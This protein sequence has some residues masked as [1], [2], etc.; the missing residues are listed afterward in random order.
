MAWQIVID[1][2]PPADK[3]NFV[4]KIRNCGEELWRVCKEDGGTSMEIA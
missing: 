3:S 1:F 2:D 4:H